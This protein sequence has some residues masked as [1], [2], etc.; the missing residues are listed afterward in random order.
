MMP[1][2]AAS[3]SG[4]RMPSRRII[5]RF[6]HDWSDRYV[7]YPVLSN[8]PPPPRHKS[9]RALLTGLAG[10]VSAEELTGGVRCRKRSRRRMSYTSFHLEML[11]SSG[12]FWRRGG[13]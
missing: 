11:R 3:Q 4:S 12:R 5:S 2:Q 8:D 9:I 13:G 1:G 7:S 10:K 6:R